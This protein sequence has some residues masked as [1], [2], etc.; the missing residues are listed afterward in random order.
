MELYSKHLNSSNWKQKVFT[1]ANGNWE[2]VD[3]VNMRK[4]ET[5][6]LRGVMKQEIV[7]DVETF[8][9]SE[10]W[11][12]DRGI[13]FSRGYLFY[14]KPGCGKTSC[15]DAIS[16][17]LKKHIYY[18]SFL[19]NVKGDEQL[20]HLLSKINYKTRMVV[21]RYRLYDRYY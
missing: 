5:I 9:S 17:M 3:S 8:C 6:S 14:G 11:Y 12:N 4:F 18:L 7:K 16:N 1:I 19:N 2:G 10:E 13:P 20:N 21:S 15:I